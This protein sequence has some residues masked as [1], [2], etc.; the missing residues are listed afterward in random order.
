MGIPENPEIH[1]QHML[2]AEK[3]V[4]ALTREPKEPL[5]DISGIYLFGSVAR[6][7]DTE[8]S[9][10]DLLITYDGP[11]ESFPFLFLN[12]VCEALESSNVPQRP[13]R[14]R[15]SEKYP[16]TVQIL[17]ISEQCFQ[18]RDGVFDDAH[19]TFFW[20][21]VRADAIRLYPE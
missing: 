5:P 10:V 17:T 20:D 15:R 8:Q 11:E 2:L 21:R 16:N 14:T 18:D 6:K 13:S 12:A 3:V 9:D 7:E 19:E 1:Q 4:H